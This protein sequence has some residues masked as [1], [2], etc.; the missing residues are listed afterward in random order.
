VHAEWD[1]N[2]YGSITWTILGAH[3]LHVLTSVLDC[4]VL[5]AA[6]L[7]RPAEDKHFVDAHVTMAYWY[8]VVAS[9]LG[10]YAVVF[11]A[12]RWIGS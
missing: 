12:P 11:L 8:F 7:T 3:A 2:V 5:G 4:L 10:V 1:V 9:F 6:L